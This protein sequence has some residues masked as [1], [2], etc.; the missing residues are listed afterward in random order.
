M[1]EEIFD[2]CIMVLVLV[3]LF[4]IIEESIISYKYYIYST[5]CRYQIV[6]GN[7]CVGGRDI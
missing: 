7:Q 2:Y 1:E 6:G 5:Y 3:E 4:C